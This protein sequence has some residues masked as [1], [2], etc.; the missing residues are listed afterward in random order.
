MKIDLK[1][2]KTESEWQR[3]IEKFALAAVP[4]WFEWL[5]WVLIL[6]VLTFVARETNSVAVKIILGISGGLFFLY[7]SNVFY[8]FEWENIPF[9]RSRAVA[10]IV[11][12]AL[13]GGIGVG[14]WFLFERVIDV[15]GERGT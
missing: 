4:K 10:R 1:V 7:F 15:L 2:K 3:A 6:G 8:R 9:V 14:L 11:S 12:I 5:G 13:A